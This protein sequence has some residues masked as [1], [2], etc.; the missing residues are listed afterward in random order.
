MSA[1]PDERGERILDSICEDVDHQLNPDGDDCP[2]C[3]GEGGTYDCI[4]GCCLTAEEGCPDC[5]TPCVECRI[6][7]RNRRRAIRRE[8]VELGDV[9][10]GIAWLKTFGQ[11]SDEITRKQVSEAL[12]REKAKMAEAAAE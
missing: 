9:D 12:K 7:E 3:G 6:Y 2:E 11:W 1:P 4:D 10:V 8:V 5:F